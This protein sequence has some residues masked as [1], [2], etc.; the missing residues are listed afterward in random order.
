MGHKEELLK[1]GGRDRFA[2]LFAL[3]GRY[4]EMITLKF[5]P[6]VFVNE[7]LFVHAGYSVDLALPVSE[8]GSIALQDLRKGFAGAELGTMIWYRGL[9]HDADR[10][11]QLNTILKASGA[12]RLVVG[13]T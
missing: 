9:V 11:N 10:C 12:R 1:H 7:T 4:G 6:M 8:L 3:G 13:H 5:L 2:E